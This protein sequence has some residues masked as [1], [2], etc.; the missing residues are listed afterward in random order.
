[1]SGGVLA[2]IRPDLGIGVALGRRAATRGSGSPGAWP[3][4]AAWVTMRGWLVMT[5]GPR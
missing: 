1:M 3:A 2:R 4:L 5:A